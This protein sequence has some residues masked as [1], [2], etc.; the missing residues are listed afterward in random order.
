M[1]PKDYHNGN[2]RQSRVNSDLKK[3]LMA[4][5]Q[6]ELSSVDYPYCHLVVNILAGQTSLTRSGFPYISESS[7]N[8]FISDIPHLFSHGQELLSWLNCVRR[9]VD[10]LRIFS[11]SE[12]SSFNRAYKVLQNIIFSASVTAPSDLWL[13]RYILSTYRKLGLNDFLSTGNHSDLFEWSHDRGLDPVQFKAD[14][15]F[16]YSRGVLNKSSERVFSIGSSPQAGDALG[17]K[18]LN[19]FESTA[20]IHGLLCEF[21][22]DLSKQS[23]DI[24]AMIRIYQDA[25]VDSLDKRLSWHATAQEVDFSWKLLPV[26]LMFRTMGWS[27]KLQQNDDISRFLDDPLHFLLPILQQ[28]SMTDQ[29]HRLTQYGERVLA[30]GPGPFGIIYAY[31]SYLVHHQSTLSGNSQKTWV[32]RKANVSASQDANRKT[33]QMA[34]EALNKFCA[35]YSYSYPLFIEHAVG[36]GEACK[37]RLAMSGDDHIQYIGADLEDAAIDAALECQKKGEL[38]LNMKFIRNADIG[39]PDILVSELGNLGFNPYGAVMMVGNGFHEIRQQTNEKMIEV[40]KQ[41]A[42][43]GLILL[44]TEESGLSDQDL[45]ETAWNTY[46]AGFRYVHEISGQGLRPAWDSERGAVYSWRKCASLGGY[47]IFDEYCTRTRSIFPHPKKND[48]N[49]S[50]SVNYF[51]VPKLIAA[52]LGTK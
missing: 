21:A 47:Y 46:H 9:L 36:Q 13:M 52:K 28:T 50:I 33:F 8:S 15:H 19:S 30:R 32:S 38:P 37:Q 42:D 27:E 26:V 3:K 25:I 45:L 48:Y 16:L 14:I 31:H 10:H 6:S 41:Y 17:L 49:P 39:C 35:H 34:N 5:I 12:R 18:S 2:I 24:S 22:S 40:F 43:A 20:D 11:E 29:F 23:D 4:G 44:F 7:F 1:E 51:C